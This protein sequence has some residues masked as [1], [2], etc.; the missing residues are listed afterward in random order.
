MG[1]ATRRKSHP[2]RG[3]SVTETVPTRV[4]RG[5]NTYDVRCRH[6]HGSSHQAVAIDLVPSSL[7]KGPG[8][9]PKGP[10]RPASRK[11]EAVLH[12]RSVVLVKRAPAQDES[13]RWALARSVVHVGNRLGIRVQTC[14]V[15]HVHMAP[16]AGP[17]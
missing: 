2:R 5:R 1:L 11:P 17:S 12:E 4:A 8:S 13:G 3:H 9:L 7:P 16:S 6:S 14:H 10:V 15:R